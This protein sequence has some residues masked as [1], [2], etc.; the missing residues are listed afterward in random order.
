MVR[1]LAYRTFQLRYHLVDPWDEQHIEWQRMATSAKQQARSGDDALTALVAQLQRLGVPL[2]ASGPS[3]AIPS[4][5][6]EF[7]G[8]IIH[9]ARGDEAQWRILAADIVFVDGDHSLGG[10]AR[11][12]AAFARKTRVL[13]GHDWH[14]KGYL[15]VPVAVLALRSNGS[16]FQRLH[17]G[18]RFSGSPLFL[19]SGY[20][21]WMRAD[22]SFALPT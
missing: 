20:C 8:V 10:V 16:A 4:S 19:D 5:V 2:Y 14:V 18:E 15:A 21:W 1:S 17:G 11:D 12:L 9:R 13:A 7:E 22:E 6:D 3:E